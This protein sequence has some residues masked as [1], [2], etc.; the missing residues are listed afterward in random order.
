ML[1]AQS[2]P[3]LCNTMDWGLS[4][5]SVHGLLQARI[6]EW[7]ATPFCR[8]SSQGS[9]PGLPHCRHLLYHQLLFLPCHQTVSRSPTTIIFLSPIVNS[10]ALKQ[11]L[12]PFTDHLVL[13]I[14]FSLGFHE[15]FPS[16][17]SSLQRPV[18]LEVSKS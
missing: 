12:T 5:F 7:V 6:Q 2:C 16:C 15:S 18:E 4:G 9:N 10:Q 8:G 14:L 13:E 17:F 1:V 11:H 3:T